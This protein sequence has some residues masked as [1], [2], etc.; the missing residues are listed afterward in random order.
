VNKNGNNGGKSRFSG[1]SEK[2]QVHILK[3]TWMWCG[4][5]KGHR[6]K[7]GWGK[8]EEMGKE[9]M[10]GDC[11]MFMMPFLVP[12]FEYSTFLTMVKKIVVENAIPAFFS[13]YYIQMKKKSRII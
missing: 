13:K 2:V 6:T 1:K 8:I 5:G 9:R 7:E 11:Q 3:Y 10:G 4:G 12:I